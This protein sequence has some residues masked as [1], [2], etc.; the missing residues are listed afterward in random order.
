MA[1]RKRRPAA[2]ATILTYFPGRG[3]A[4]YHNRATDQRHPEDRSGW[5]RVAAVPRGK[6]VGRRQEGGRRGQNVGRRKII[7]TSRVSN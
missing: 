3:R 1:A 6:S 7:H 5:G 2:V 4:R